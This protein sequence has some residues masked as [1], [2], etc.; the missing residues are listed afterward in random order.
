MTIPISEAKR[1]FRKKEAEKIRMW[2]PYAGTSR[3]RILPNP[4]DKDRFWKDVKVHWDRDTGKYKPCE[5]HCPLCAEYDHGDRNKKPYEK[6][7]LNIYDYYDGKVKVWLAGE[8]V[9]KQ[10]LDFCNRSNDGNIAH[11]TKGQD[12]EISKEEANPFVRFQIRALDQSQVK[13]KNIESELY[14]LNKVASKMFVRNKQKPKK[15][16]RMVQVSNTWED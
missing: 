6:V 3:I 16:L 13:L 4:S 8:R 1:L 15:M 10:L 11:P 7:L 12:L 9:M 2:H 5:K 14:H